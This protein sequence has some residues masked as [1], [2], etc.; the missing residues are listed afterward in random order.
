MMRE[1]GLQGI[2]SLDPLLINY[3]SDIGKDSSSTHHN[4]EEEMTC[5]TGRHLGKAMVNANT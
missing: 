1:K 4:S 3:W 5:A 2:I